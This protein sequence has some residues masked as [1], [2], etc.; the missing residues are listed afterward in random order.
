MDSVV[1]MTRIKKELLGHLLEYGYVIEKVSTLILAIVFLI[2]II[3]IPNWYRT[4]LNYSLNPQ[5]YGVR[6]I[7]TSILITVLM[8]VNAF[9]A[10]LIPHFAPSLRPRGFRMLKD[11]RTLSIYL[12]LIASLLSL[13]ILSYVLLVSQLLM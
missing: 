7:G 13:S 10:Y 12:A 11:R 9:I 3:V 6:Y 4:F 2:T 1:G 5:L 8:L